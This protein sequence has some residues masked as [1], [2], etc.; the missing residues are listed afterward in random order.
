MYDYELFEIND[1]D[2]LINLMENNDNT[3]QKPDA[4]ESTQRE[5][6]IVQKLKDELEL[7]INKNERFTNIREIFFFRVSYL[8]SNREV[9]KQNVYENKDEQDI[10]FIVN[11]NQQYKISIKQQ[12]VKVF[13]K[14]KEKD[15]YKQ[16]KKSSLSGS[17]S[18][19]YKSTKSSS[20]NKK[21]IYFS[22]TYQDDEF[23]L[24]VEHTKH[25]VDGNLKVK[26][27]IYNMEKT[28]GDYLYYPKDVGIN[29][30]E[31][32][33]ILV[34]VKQNTTFK[35]LLNQMEVLVKD[36]K[37]LLPEQKFNYFGFV[38][39]ESSN[40]DSEEKDIIDYIRNILSYNNN[41]KIF[42]FVIK[43]NELLGLSLNDQIDYPTHYYNVIEK[44]MAEMKTEVK[45]EIGKVKTE[46]KDIKTEIT[47]MKT[48]MEKMSKNIEFIIDKLLNQ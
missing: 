15:D 40:K 25:E 37:V 12:E 16:L 48:E 24:K 35:I 2:L 19:T 36:F 5:S 26:N 21:F 4:C 34:E 17:E 32:E 30:D 42:L 23:F 31:G 29:M 6:L 7:S 20:N 38:N 33:Q 1:F 47:K 13:R 28:L 8:N 18:R 41:F 39:E 14:G 44:K 45:T 11:E 22:R 43:K 27:K 46:I 10:I 3:N 9:I